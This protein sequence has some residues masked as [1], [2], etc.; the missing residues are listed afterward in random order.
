MVPNKPGIIMVARNAAAF[1]LIVDGTSI[2]RAGPAG[3]PVTG[4]LLDPNTL[5][6]RDR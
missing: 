1:E 3:R 4:K 5:R 6:P 2:G